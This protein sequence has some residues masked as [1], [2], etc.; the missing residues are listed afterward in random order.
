VKRPTRED[1][2]GYVLGALDEPDAQ[3][4]QSCIQDDPELVHQLSQI[5]AELE[6]LESL[7]SLRLSP[8]PALARRTCQLVAQLDYANSFGF[9]S[10]PDAEPSAT[11]DSPPADTSWR[12][13][14]RKSGRGGPTLSLNAGGAVGTRR[15]ALRD[16][17]AIAAM[18]LLLGSVLVPAM[19]Y[20]RHQS[21]IVACQNNLREIG[22]GMLGYADNSGGRL[23]EIP[24]DPRL[25]VVGYQVPVLLEGGWIEHPRLISCPGA[26]AK[27]GV[28]SIPTLDQ[29]RHAAAD[30]L[31]DLHRAIGGP[32]AYPAG[33]RRNGHYAPTVVQDRPTFA[34]IADKSSLFRA[35]QRS[36]NHG[37]KGQNCFFEDGHIEFVSSATIADDSIYLNDLN[38]VGPGVDPSDIVVAPSH[39]PVYPLSEVNAGPGRD[40]M[41]ELP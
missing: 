10:I 15:W 14:P 29:M 23:V 27:D 32:F 20:T 19:A 13:W 5:R 33:V 30:E 16:V 25:G 4:V 17:L 7:A 6:P 2:L 8:P 12:Y 28:A 40:D 18:L 35:D 24:N 22:L 31:P 21:R 39:I 37:G 26:A 3:H 41:A 36:G 38:E 1:L 34:L 9:P 11:D